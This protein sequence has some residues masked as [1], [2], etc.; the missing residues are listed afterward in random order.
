M[1]ELTNQPEY[2]KKKKRER[3]KKSTCRHYKSTGKTWLLL[4]VIGEN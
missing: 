3:K 4:M 2:T 1:H